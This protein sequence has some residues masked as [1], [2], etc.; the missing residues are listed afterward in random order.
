MQWHVVYVCTVVVVVLDQ[1]ECLFVLP[2]GSRGIYQLLRF[3]RG[4]RLYV[5]TA[6]SGGA[7]FLVSLTARQARQSGFILIQAEA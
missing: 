5:Q 6:V 4:R 7:L 2:T 1:I 3:G